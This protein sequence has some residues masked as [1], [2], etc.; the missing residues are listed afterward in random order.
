MRAMLGIT[1][2]GLALGC[3]GSETGT[4]Q[5]TTYGESY[6]EEQ[7]P[8]ASGGGEGFADGYTVKF[9]KFLVALGGLS[10]ADRDGRVGTEHKGQKIFDVHGKGPHPVHTATIEARR[11]DRVG[12]SVAK[13][14]GAVA[15]NAAAADVS[16]LNDKG[17]SVYVAGEAAK[18]G[19]KV[20]FAWGFTTETGYRECREQTTGDGVAV[21]TGGTAT[22]QFTIHGD[23]LFY[24]DLQSTDPSLRF[25][26]IAAADADGNGEVTLDELAKVDLTTLPTGQYGTGGDGSVTHLG[27]FVTALTRT[28]V[29]YQG[30]GHC[31]S[32]GASH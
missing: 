22:I 17:Y 31:H 14:Q 8:A 13:A 15:G 30:E 18:G 7:I 3:G 28:L 21:P 10:I 19:K 12:I 11:W 6:I 5:V 32:G 24:D 2:A 25:E 16:L 9:S 23:H 27:G 26:A 29:H 4:V 1:L 20:T